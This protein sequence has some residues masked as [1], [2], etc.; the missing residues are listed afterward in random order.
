MRWIVALFVGLAIAG[1]VLRG[2]LIAWVAAT[3][4]ALLLLKTWRRPAK[5]DTALAVGLVSVSV[6][7]WVG[8]WFYVVSVWESGEV[9]ELAID[10]PDGV[11]TARLWVMDVGPNPVVFYDAEP[12]VARA[13]LSG[14]PLGFTRAGKQ[15]SRIPHASEAETLSEARSQ[16]VLG[17]MAEQYGQRNSAAT[18]YYL[19]L[20]RLRHR[21]ALVVELLE[22]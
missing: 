5:I 12:R 9:V 1:V 19:L 16:E 15:S 2:G 7:A 4:S 14:R 17:A 3:L 22:P 10:T 8:T 18:V 6:L 11:H 20:G 13:L 21:V